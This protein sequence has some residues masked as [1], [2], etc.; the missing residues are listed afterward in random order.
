MVTTT[1]VEPRIVPRLIVNGWRLVRSI[2]RDV[3]NIRIDASGQKT[4]T[5]GR[6]PTRCRCDTGEVDPNGDEWDVIIVGAGTAGCV[7]AE[8]LSRNP[9]VRVLLLEAGPASPTAPADLFAALNAPGRLWTGLT[10]R[11]SAGGPRRAYPRGRGL[12]GSGAVNGLLDLQPPMSDLDRWATVGL[13]LRPTVDRYP[14]ELATTRWGPADRLLSTAGRATGLPLVRHATV[15][16]P[17][18]G[19]APLHAH[20]DER[21]HLTRASTDVTHLEP[22]RHRPNLGVLTGVHVDELLGAS[23]GTVCGVR[24]TTASGTRRI[25]APLTVVCTGAIHTPALLLRS[26][27][28]RP[29]IGRN[30][31]DHAAVGVT[32]HLRTP[33][34]AET[35]AT[36]ALG[37]TADGLQFLPL[38]RL[39]TT[40]ELRALGALMVGVLGSRGRGRVSLDTDGHPL[41]Q[42]DL[43]SDAHDRTEIV[44]AAR[45]LFVIAQRPEVRAETTDVSID[46]H[47]TPVSETNAMDDDALLHWTLANLADYV[48]ATGTCAYGSAH[49]P[50][51]VVGAGGLVHGTS[52]L[53]VID[54]SVFPT[55]PHVNPWRSTVMLAATLA[56]DLAAAPT[57]RH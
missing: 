51:A 7:V 27:L 6:R 37:H 1:F 30:L 3:R 15:N 36:C 22:A 25:R 44:K 56:D 28:T 46:D 12:G 26:G 55:P 16:H 4:N 50:M 41:V 42:F 48:H 29:G 17:G 9:D 49:D 57:V 11:R 14:V 19:P 43:L 5:G 32:L 31:A 40:P 21:G 8:R 2:R 18:I 24:A 33:A 23:E 54:A 20:I 34:E 10:A 45:L 38:N 52:G 35:P 39:G 53:A 47:G 13:V